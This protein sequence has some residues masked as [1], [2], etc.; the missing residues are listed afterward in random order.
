LLAK[1]RLFFVYVLPVLFAVA[2]VTHTLYPELIGGKIAFAILLASMVGFFTNFIAIKMLF[3]PQ[4]PTVFGRQGLIPKKQ[5]AIATNLGSSINQQFFNAEELQAYLEQK[6]L[7]HKASS[8]MK[9]M[10]RQALSQPHNQ[11]KI[12]HWLSQQISQNNEQISQYLVK[13]VEQQ[14]TN[15]IASQVNVSELANKLSDYIEAGIERGDIDI[16]QV[17]DQFAEVAAENIPELATWLHQQLD[18]YNQSQSL[19]KRNFISFLRWSSD[20][21]E[22]ALREQLYRL[23]STLEFRSGVYQVAERMLLSVGDFLQ[24]DAGE[25]HLANFNQAINNYLTASAKDKV[26]PALITQLEDY[27]A[28]KE[29][30]KTIETLLNQLIDN[31]EQQLA[32]HLQS[33]QFRNQLEQWLPIMLEQFD[34]QDFIQQKVKGL[35]TNRLEQLVLS[36]AKEHLVA[37]EILGGVLGAFAG[38]ALFSM[39]AF[40]VLL[41]I[42]L[43]VLLIEHYLSAT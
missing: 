5:S 20:V 36:A 11:Q 39:P 41:T 25:R 31:A 42:S 22:K 14:F 26:I 18:D 32:S 27:L 8:S 1:V 19:F 16:E 3:R 35:D 34:M 17:V 9:Q 12:S 6:Q 29:A 33:Q 21:D 7:L 13:I 40:L 38:I 10:L 30:W 2:A 23:I 28:S 4:I 24:T 15:L 37:I 43:S